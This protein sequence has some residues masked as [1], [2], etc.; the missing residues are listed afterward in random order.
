MKS[1]ISFYTGLIIISIL[2]YMII[3]TGC[4]KFDEEEE[5][6]TYF[7]VEIDSISLADTITTSDTLSISFYGTVGNNG[8]YSFSHFYPQTNEDTIN[9]EVWGKLAPGENCTSVMVYLE[10]EQLNILNFDEGTY[11]VHVKQPGGGLLTDSLT[12]VPSG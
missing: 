2:G 4:V 9:I 11:F 8:C 1:K 5:Q 7:L 12:V 3:F 10:G 6:D